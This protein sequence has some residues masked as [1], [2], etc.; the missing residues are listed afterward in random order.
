MAKKHREAPAESQGTS[1]TEDTSATP[2]ITIQGLTFA[3]SAPYAEGQTLTANL[4]GALN[5][6]RGENLRNNFA[7]RIKALLE[8]KG[9]EKREI[10]SLS[11]EEKAQLQLDFAEYDS[12]Y[13]LSGKRVAKAPIDP[14]EKEATR[15][16]K[17]IIDGALRKK[18]VDKKALA[19]GQYDGYVQALLANKPE[20]REQARAY[21]ENLRGAANAAIADDILAPAA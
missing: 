10:T 12:K 5:N 7:A 20:I 17:E 8:P 18:G 1:S 14:V 21:I 11:D 16:A 13:E 9:G 15:M 19:E 3:Y 2:T 6:L 4:A